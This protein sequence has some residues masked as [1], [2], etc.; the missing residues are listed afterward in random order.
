[1]KKLQ[2]HVWAP[3]RFRSG[4]IKL[5]TWGDQTMQ[6]Y[7]KFEGFPWISTEQ[8][9]VWVGNLVDETRCWRIRM[10][11]QKISRSFIDWFNQGGWAKSFPTVFPSHPVNNLIEWWYRNP[12]ILSHHALWIESQTVQR[13]GVWGDSPLYHDIQ[14]K[15]M[16]ESR[17]LRAK[18]LEWCDGQ[19]ISMA[20][21][22]VADVQTDWLGV[23]TTICAK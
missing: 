20:S 16:V 6:I 13:L 10:D 5:P 21:K 11:T 8:C 15:S 23:G 2:A 19:Y 12:E 1:M 17:L 7:G 3:Q 14:M 4:I 22:W 18:H 9:I